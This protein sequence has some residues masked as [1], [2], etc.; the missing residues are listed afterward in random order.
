M[1]NILLLTS[2]LLWYLSILRIK[3]NKF[4]TYKIKK[5][6]ELSPLFSIVGGKPFCVNCERTKHL[7]FVQAEN[8][9]FI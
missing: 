6:F 3:L 7:N 1:F 4:E 2:Y 9:R 8:I 5:R